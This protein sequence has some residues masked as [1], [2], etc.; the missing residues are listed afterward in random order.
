MKL[1]FVGDVVGESGCNMLASHLYKLKKE[2]EIDITVVN[3]E[4]SAQGNGI[5]PHSA[6]RLF[7]MGV[8]VIT[9]GNHC[10]RRKEIMELYESN[11][12][13]LRPAN[14]PD[15]VQGHGV[16]VIDLFPVKIAVINL[17]GTMYLEPV[18]NPFNM[19]DKLLEEIDT[20]QILLWIF[21]LKLQARRKQWVF[22]F[23]AGLPLCSVHIPMFRRLTKRYL[24]IIL[25]ISLMLA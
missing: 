14:F 25:H 10:F 6:N 4:N 23:K 18:D 9:T 17:I 11:N 7:S 12:D 22:I 5:T 19:V 21:M 2:Y 15:E 13:L 8:D 20:L 24:Q 16:A 3:G 1:L